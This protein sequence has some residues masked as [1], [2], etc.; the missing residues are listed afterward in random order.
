MLVFSDH[1]LAHGERWE[2]KS[3]ESWAQC[4]WTR[5]EKLL[6]RAKLIISFAP[7]QLFLILVLWGE[8][9]YGYWGTRCSPTAS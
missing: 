3:K 4:L 7:Q 9:P 6:C 5:E 8:V 1:Y 2:L